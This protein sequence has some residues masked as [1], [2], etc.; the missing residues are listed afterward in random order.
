[1]LY[2]LIGIKVEFVDFKTTD[3]ETEAP[4][5]L[6]IFLSPETTHYENLIEQILTETV[7]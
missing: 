2:H 7:R 1:M 6:S 3:E 4:G 5:H